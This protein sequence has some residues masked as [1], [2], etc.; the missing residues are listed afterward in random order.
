[1]KIS[2][3]F[4]FLYFAQWLKA[5]FALAHSVTSVVLLEE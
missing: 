4:V 1:M 2:G 5:R 3:V